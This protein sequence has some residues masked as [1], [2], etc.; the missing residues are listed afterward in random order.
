MPRELIAAKTGAETSGA[1]RLTDRE[2]PA[3]LSAN[4]LATTET[5]KLEKSD[6]GGSTFY[7]V[8]EGGADTEL[9]LDTNAFRIVARGIYRVVKSATAAS[10]GVFITDD[11]LN[12]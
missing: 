4:G 3:T 11:A 9:D 10:V 2:L 12:V 7:Q 1:F 6:D 5:V 8:V